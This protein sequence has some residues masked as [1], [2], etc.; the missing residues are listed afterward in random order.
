MIMA[1]L[2]ANHFAFAQENI[3]SKLI[4]PKL[5]ENRKLP[6]EN[7][8]DKKIGAVKKIKENIVSHYNFYFNANNKLNSVL[9]SA[10]QIFKDN[11][12]KLIPVRDFSIDQT[13]GMQAELDSVIIKCNNGILLH[14]LRN[15]WID[16]LYLLMGK[17]YFFE[18]KFDSAYD[19]FQYINYNFQPR[20]KN[21]IGFEKTIGSNIN[22]SG[23]IY[24]VSTIEKKGVLNSFKHQI[25]RNE[26]LVWIAYTLMEMN[27]DDEAKSLLD[28]LSMDSNFPERLKPLLS[29]KK[30]EWFLKKE[31]N[32]SAAYYLEKSL[33]ICIDNKEKA[34]RYFLIGQLYAS[35]DKSDKAYAFFEKSI[36]IT[37]NP[38]MEAY[39][40]IKQVAG[41]GR[42]TDENKRIEDNIQ[43]L[44]TLAGKEKYISFKPIIFSSIAVLELKRNNTNSAIEYLKKSNLNNQ[45]DQGLKNNNF[46]KIAE[47]AFAMKKYSLAKEYLDS[48]DESSLTNKN[49]ILLKKPII[50]EIVNNLDIISLEDSL[51]HLA[52]LTDEERLKTLSTILKNHKKDDVIEQKEKSISKGSMQKN[53]LLDQTSGALFSNE[54]QKTE[55]YFNNPSLIA[56]G[57]IEFKNK[58]GDR[59]NIDNW[60]RSATFNSIKNIIQT[61]KESQTGNELGVED[62]NNLTMEILLEKIPLTP[63]KL[64]A[65]YQKKYTAYSALG[66]I[67]KNKLDDCKES[68]SWNE[69][70]INESSAHINEQTYFDL[71]FCYKK[72]GNKEKHLYYQDLLAN[73]FPG[74]TLTLFLKDPHA[75]E[76]IEKEKE[77]K[78]TNAYEEIYDLMIA[79]KF[80]EA[81][82]KKTI[83]DSIY[84]QNKWS[85]QLLYIES[86]YYIN[87][88]QDSAAIETLGKITSLYPN[89]PLSE[90]AILFASVISRRS[91]IEKELNEKVVEREREETIDWIE[92]GP[93]TRSK[94]SEVKID[95]MVRDKEPVKLLKTIKMDTTSLVSTVKAKKDEKYFFDLNESQYVL[96]ILNDVD[97]IYT[98]E[99]KRA[100]A[101]YNKRKFLDKNLVIQQEKIDDKTVLKI[102]EFKNII[103]AIDYIDQGKKLGPTEIFPWLPAQKYS[104][105]LISP[106]NLK[107]LSTENKLTPYLDFIK[108]QLPGKF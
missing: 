1:L 96:L 93:V 107:I 46:I 87:K 74:S 89:S 39:A 43:A 8:T 58:W 82:I 32:D 65:S 44:L 22:N 30:A 94:V 17:A 77:I 69:R 25:V 23:N 53:D 41:M 9:G 103:E 59:P 67:F 88:R 86:L 102:S 99:A 2:C 11:Y 36:S 60:R 12:D 101:N 97:I 106:S 51:Q 6:S 70:L 5:Y 104:F 105:L 92:D 4:K 7:I 3:T 27:N 29:E 26:A 66:E 49:E 42:G 78:A 16:D 68:I 45:D 108:I 37:T 84:G 81:F 100:I 13:A 24:T 75:L 98:N 34:R 54:K 83:A 10:K 91:E 73:K 21:E 38:L 90:K 95:S 64:L 48:V 79:G 57:K 71:A 19:I 80:E 50:K 52:K 63:E 61:E 85:P 35:I 14:D 55:W 62:N 76:K 28:L 72:E 15:D 20:E 47:L 56:Q 31:Q 33:S 18:K 40:R